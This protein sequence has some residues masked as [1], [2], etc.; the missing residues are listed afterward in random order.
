[1]RAVKEQTVPN[2]RPECIFTPENRDEYKIAKHNRIEV[3]HCR[4]AR[5]TDGGDRI[6]SLHRG[7]IPLPL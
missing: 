6:E 7:L 1:M 4:K 5:R 2:R 3:C